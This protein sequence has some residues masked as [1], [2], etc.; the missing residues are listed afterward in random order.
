MLFMQ[1]K[2]NGNSYLL[3][4]KDIIEIVPYVNLQ[5]IPKA[6]AYLAGL[7]NYR[8]DSVPVVDI[9]MLMS[10]RPCEMKLSSRIAMANYKDDDGRSVCIGLLIERL[11]ETATYNES[12]FSD[13][14][15]TLEESPYL[16]KVVV[17]DNRIVQMVN[18]REIIPE[19]AHDILFHG[20][21]SGA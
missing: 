19:A 12:D 16:G 3:E 13:S 17:D 10:D 2:I 4:A 8:G 15:V 6:P 1:F 7:L 14:G 18:V 5:Q 21:H 20:N 11:T 9:C